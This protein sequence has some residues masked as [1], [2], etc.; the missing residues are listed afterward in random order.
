MRFFVSFLLYNSLR[1]FFPEIMYHLG[2]KVLSKSS[3]V[4]FLCEVIQWLLQ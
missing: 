4:D 1:I 3:N 2:K